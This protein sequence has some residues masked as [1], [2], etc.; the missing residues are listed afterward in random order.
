[1]RRLELT[2]FVNRYN[3]FE[4][5][6]LRSEVDSNQD[7]GTWYGLDSKLILQDIQNPYRFFHTPSWALA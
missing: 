5:R 6:Q 1:M 7:S 2:F 4:C 3:L